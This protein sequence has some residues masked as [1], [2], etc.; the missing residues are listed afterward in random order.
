[1]DLARG[2]WVPTRRCICC[3]VHLWSRPMG[4]IWLTTHDLRCVF[5]TT[6]QCS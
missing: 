5:A 6:D 1:M 4:K 3:S 2:A